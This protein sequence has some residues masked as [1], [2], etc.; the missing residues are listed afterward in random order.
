MPNAEYRPMPSIYGH[1]A[2]RPGGNVEDTKFIDDALRE[3]LA[4]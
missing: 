4:S 2:G 1:L 3:L